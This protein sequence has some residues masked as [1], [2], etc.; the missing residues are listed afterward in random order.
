VLGPGHTNTTAERDPPRISRDGRDS[1]ADLSH[2][3]RASFV[4]KSAMVDLGAGPF[5]LFRFGV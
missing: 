4:G 1:I 5:S 2:V 3:Y